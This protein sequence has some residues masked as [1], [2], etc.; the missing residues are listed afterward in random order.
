[1]DTLQEHQPTGKTRLSG[2]GLFGY[3]FM[4]RGEHQDK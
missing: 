3:L 2:D 1:M 4:S